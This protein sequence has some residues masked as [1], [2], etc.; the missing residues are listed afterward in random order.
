MVLGYDTPLTTPVDI[1]VERGRKIA[2][3]GTNGLGKSTLLKTLLGMQPPVSGTVERGDFVSVGY[4][5]QES[6]AGIRIPRW[7]SSGRHI[8]AARTSRFARRSP[9]AG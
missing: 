2:I 6:P 1:R 8:P 3:R 7:R 5:E 9:P 4:F